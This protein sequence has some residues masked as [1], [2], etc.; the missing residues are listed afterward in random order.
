MEALPPDL[1]GIFD[2]M[3][4]GAGIVSQVSAPYVLRMDHPLI[5]LI[6]RAIAKAEAEGQFDDLPGAGKP[7]DTSRDPHMALVERAREG[8][9]ATSPIAVV[10]GQISEVKARLSGLTGDA[11][12]APVMKELADLELRLALEIEAVKRQG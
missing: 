2:K 12:R 6:D 11:A 1:R 9:T 7:L 3:R 8:A 4:V 5:S 10:R